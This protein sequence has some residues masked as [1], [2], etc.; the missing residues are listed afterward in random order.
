MTLLHK[1][2][3]EYTRYTVCGDHRSLLLSQDYTMLQ[4]VK[5]MKKI[6]GFHAQNAQIL[7]LK[8]VN[9]DQE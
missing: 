1:T 7:R 4:V 8:V 6:G 9:F 2:T 5:L 3:V